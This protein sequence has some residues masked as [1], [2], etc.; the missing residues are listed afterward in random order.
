[1]FNLFDREFALHPP[2][3]LFHSNTFE[4]DSELRELRKQ[5]REWLTTMDDKI[6][7]RRKALLQEYEAN[8]PARYSRKY[9]S[10]HSNINGKELSE[11]KD[12]VEENHDGRKSIQQKAD[13]VEKDDGKI[14]DEEHV[15]VQLSQDKA[16]KNKW[17]VTH[18]GK[19]TTLDATDSTFG[20]KL[21]VLMTTNSSATRTNDK[22]GSDAAKEAERDEEEEEEEE[23]DDLIEEIESENEPDDGVS[24]PLPTAVMQKRT[25]K[26]I[27][28]LVAKNA[29]S[30]K[31]KK[32]KNS[33]GKKK[34][35]QKK[36]T[37]KQRKNRT[38]ARP[39]RKK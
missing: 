19:K 26:A 15:D 4:D 34:K 18:G 24:T 13:K 11:T 23:D 16:D 36:S 6:Q 10:S 7:S 12:V 2:M 38:S 20:E 33:K 35:K 14:V 9:S 8:N 27:A 37:K 1:M 22:N 5:R 25:S 31:N 21:Q 30:K 3:M 28:S 39:S 17:T 32:G 29:N